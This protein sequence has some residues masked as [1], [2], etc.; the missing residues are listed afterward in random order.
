[1]SLF[2]EI[3][4]QIQELK[5]NIKRIQ[6]RMRFLRKNILENHNLK[7]KIE[8]LKQ[9]INTLLQLEDD[10]LTVDYSEA[11]YIPKRANH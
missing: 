3:N 11:R 5:T 9:Q 6:A 8:S 1:M 2:G 10:L 4:L 7:V